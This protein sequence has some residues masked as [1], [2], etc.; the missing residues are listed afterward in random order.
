MKSFIF[1][2]VAIFGLTGC[3]KMEN[4][5]TNPNAVSQPVASTLLTDLEKNLFQFSDIVSISSNEG[6][7]YIAMAVALQYQVG[8]SSH[9]LLGGAYTWNTNTTSEYLQITDAQAMISSSG[10]NT[11]Y[12]ALAKLFMAINYYSLTNKFGDVPCSQALQLTS[13]IKTPVY[14]PQ[15]D[16]YKTILAD[17]DTANNLLASNLG[18]VKGDFI[19][20]GDLTKWRKFVNSFRLRVILSLSNKAG[21]ADMDPVPLFNAV[22]N[23]PS[24]YPLFQSNADNAQIT[25]TL[26]VPYPLYNNPEYVYYGM[27]KPFIDSLRLYQD[28]RIIHWASITNAASNAGLSVNDY[29][30]YDGLQPD[31]SMS[32]NTTHAAVAS[33]IKSN[34]FSDPSYEPNLF[35]GYSEV[36]FIVAEGIARGW[37]LDDASAQI[38]YNQGITASFSYY[39][40]PQNAIDLY[41]TG[42]H[43]VYNPSIGLKQILF[44]RYIASVYNSGYE[45]YFSQRRTGYPAMAVAGSGVPTHQQALRWK[46]PVSEY[47]L[48]GINVKA[49]VARQ[50]PLGDIITEKMWLLKP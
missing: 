12:V 22:M 7:F 8:F 21:D 31:S 32:Y 20:N 19:Y 33:G 49:A 45:P 34:Y 29:N 16:V 26:V 36:N 48:N 14:D 39:N 6:A 23:N 13:N 47:T 5:Q 44:Q 18:K 46:Y 43:V 30:A 35:M 40:I 42:P 25:T 15:K 27:A 11:G 28:P 38:Y 17:L 4:F 24:Q 9:S 37:W 1:I 2:L 3:K 41:L 10:D 50:Y